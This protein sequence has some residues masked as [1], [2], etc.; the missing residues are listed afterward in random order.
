[1]KRSI[2]MTLAATLILT[3][4]TLQA[5]PQGNGKHP[6]GLE[7]IQNEVKK[8]EEKLNLTASESQEMKT[9]YTIFFEKIKPLRNNENPETSRETFNNAI[10][11]RDAKVKALLKSDERYATY[12]QIL[13]EG[14]NRMRDRVREHN[15]GDAPMENYAQLKQKLALN[16]TQSNNLDE[17]FKNYHQKM[18]ELRQNGKPAE[19]FDQMKALKSE[20]NA[21]VKSLLNNDKK[22]IIYLE[23]LNEKQDDMRTKIKERRQ[24]RNKNR[25][26]E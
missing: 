16:E 21:K 4:T 7:K 14:Q 8:I 5:Q 10:E 11:E 18:K 23:T 24:E 17:I 12:Q 13:A 26:T 22:Y 15:T 20:R 9:I 19:N 25:P 1:M 6:S 3:A 2:K